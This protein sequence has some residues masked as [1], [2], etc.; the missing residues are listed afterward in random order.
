MFPWFRTPGSGPGA[1][2]VEMMLL[3][4]QGFLNLDYGA[5]LGF[6]FRGLGGLWV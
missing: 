3:Q 2:T 5:E 1:E 6:G 4:G